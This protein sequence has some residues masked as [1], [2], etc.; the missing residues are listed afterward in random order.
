M[1]ETDYFTEQVLRKRPYLTLEM[2]LSV[3]AN[4]LRSEIQSDGRYRFWGHVVLKGEEK[5]RI[6]RIVTLEDGLT[7]H[8]AFVD[9]NF[10][11]DAP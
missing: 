1:P 3:L 10:R 8:N 7:L 5:T 11:E 9:R 6:L 2:C 4:P